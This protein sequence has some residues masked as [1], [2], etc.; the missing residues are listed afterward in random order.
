MT[1]SLSAIWLKNRRM[2][3]A[4]HQQTKT[5]KN[6]TWIAPARV[7]NIEAGTDKTEITFDDGKTLSAALLI[8]ADGRNSFV[9]RMAGIGTTEWP[10]HQKA[11]VDHGGARTTS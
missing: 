1:V 9:R 2:R 7:A 4:L 6:I 10:C 11:I 3:H 5:Q 8:A